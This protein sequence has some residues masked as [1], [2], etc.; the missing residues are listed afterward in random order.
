MS[1]FPTGGGN[2]PEQV[3]GKATIPFV[4]DLSQLEQ[5]KDRAVE[6]AAEI[7]RAFAQALSLTEQRAELDR[8]LDGFLA[9]LGLARELIQSVNQPQAPTRGEQAPTPIEQVFSSLAEV[10]DTL[11]EIAAD[12]QQIASNTTPKD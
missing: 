5:G 8:W 2:A 11:K 7:G 9:R 10:K 6:M 4:P 12:T 1:G 3:L